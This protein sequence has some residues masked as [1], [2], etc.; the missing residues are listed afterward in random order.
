IIT[1]QT[2]P[3]VERQRVQK[4]LA[5]AWVFQLD[6]IFEEHLSD[7]TDRSDVAVSPGLISVPRHRDFSRRNAE[8]RKTCILGRVRIEQVRTSAMLA[9]V[10][11][12]RILLAD[13]LLPDV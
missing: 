2:V 3:P 4:I 13:E 9:S 8:I 12:A 10:R 6:L 5:R 7:R 11:R 1:E